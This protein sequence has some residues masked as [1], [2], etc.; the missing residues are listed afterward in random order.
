MWDEIERTAIRGSAE[1]L[2]LLDE[3]Q[4]QLQLPPKIITF[5]TRGAA[6]TID[7]VFDTPEIANRIVKCDVRDEIHHDFDHHFIE[8]VIILEVPQESPPLPR[9]Q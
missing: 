7:L 3:F 4:L 2:N 8:T 5:Q 9:R 6:S 1:L